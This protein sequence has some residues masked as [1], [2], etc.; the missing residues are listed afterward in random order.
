MI[1]VENEW[2]VF[3]Y[4]F[5]NLKK[6]LLPVVVALFTLKCTRGILVACPLDKVIYILEVV[7]EC[8][9]AYSTLVGDVL[10]CNIGKTLF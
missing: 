4:R 1:Y 10:D 6:A 8:H 2:L 5:E 3:S 7:V 9:S